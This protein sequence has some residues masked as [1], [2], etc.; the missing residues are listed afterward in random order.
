MID[1]SRARLYPKRL[2]LRNDASPSFEGQNG[3]RLRPSKHDSN[4]WEV[5]RGLASRGV[6]VSI[7]LLTA[8]M[9]FKNLG[10]LSHT[11]SKGGAHM[12]A[13]LLA[14]RCEGLSLTAA[15][16]RPYSR[17]EADWCRRATERG[18]DRC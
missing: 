4:R 14:G 12:W 11:M 10:S 1:L 2:T 15:R 5:R 18:E 3:I 13:D 7:G 17:G 8:L 16:R 6:I 9:S